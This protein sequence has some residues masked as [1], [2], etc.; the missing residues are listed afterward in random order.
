MKIR[1]LEE[2]ARRWSRRAF[3]YV[4]AYVGGGPYRDESRDR[5]WILGSLR[6]F[7][8]DDVREAIVQN[9]GYGH[10]ERWQILAAAFGVN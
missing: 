7:S 5:K 2:T 4:F 3:G 8:A 10:P 6:R 1:S 9:K